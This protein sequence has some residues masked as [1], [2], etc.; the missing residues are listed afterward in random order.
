MFLFDCSIDIPSG[1][2]VEEGEPKDGGIKPH[3]L[4]SLT[5][6]KLCARK[7]AG[8]Y[9]YLGGRFVPPSLEDKY[10]LDLPKYPGIDPVV[11]LNEFLIMTPST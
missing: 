7:F 2:D 4:I 8:R 11:L 9:H 3:A 1:W 6:P 10:Q 5:T